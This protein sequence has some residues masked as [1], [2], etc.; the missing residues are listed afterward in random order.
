MIFKIFSDM[1]GLVLILLMTAYL[2]VTLPAVAK[3][4][5]EIV[6]PPPENWPEP[7]KD[8]QPFWFL[9]I[10]RLEYDVNEGADEHE[11]DDTDNNNNHDCHDIHHYCECQ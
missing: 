10:D 11:D 9:L 5:S 3:Q 4:D 1:L 7:I 6:S 2:A 8:N